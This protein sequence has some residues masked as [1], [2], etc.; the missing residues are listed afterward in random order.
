MLWHLQYYLVDA[1]GVL[2]LHG[3]NLELIRLDKFH[4]LVCHEG[5]HALDFLDWHLP[6]IFQ[7][8]G[9]STNDERGLHLILKNKII[10]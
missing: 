10:R 2:V 4:S 6:S 1:P 3:H 7:D 8:H 9:L 5:F